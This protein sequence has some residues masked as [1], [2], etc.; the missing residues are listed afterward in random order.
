MNIYQIYNRKKREI[1]YKKVKD[2]RAISE[3]RF[4]DFFPHG[5]RLLVTEVYECNTVSYWIM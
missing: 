3:L 4:G 2:Q 1:R 5:N